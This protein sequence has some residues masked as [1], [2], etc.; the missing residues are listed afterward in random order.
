MSKKINLAVDENSVD[1]DILRL[2]QD[3]TELIM[4]DPKAKSVSDDSPHSNNNPMIVQ[5]MTTRKRKTDE[6]NKKTENV[7]RKQRKQLSDQNEVCS[8][9]H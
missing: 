8:I 2:S 7:A 4:T 5:R 1:V 9:H 3:D 6:S